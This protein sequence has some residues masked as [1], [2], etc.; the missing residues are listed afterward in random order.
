MNAEQ[1]VAPYR[2]RG[3]AAAV[4][5]CLAGLDRRFVAVL[6]MDRLAG[7]EIDNDAAY[8]DLL[9]LGAGEMHLDAPALRIV[10]GV[11]LEGGEIEIGAELAIDAGKQIEVEFR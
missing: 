8:P 1:A 6:S 5:E 11:V 2:K 7:A 9:P 3:P 4:P 10:E